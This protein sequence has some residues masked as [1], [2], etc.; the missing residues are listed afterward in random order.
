MHSPCRRHA[1][2]KR[3]RLPVNSRC[4]ACRPRLTA[5]QGPRVEQ[6]ASLFFLRLPE[7][8][9]AIARVAL[10]VRQGGHDIPEDVIRRR[11]DAGLRHF[12]TVYKPEVDT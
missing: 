10:R 5:A 9:N 7:V 11:F 1:L 8:E 2:A 6:Q 3:S 12:E 4:A